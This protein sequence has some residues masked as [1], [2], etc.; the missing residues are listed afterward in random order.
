MRLL[1]I[2]IRNFRSYQEQVEIS[3][4]NLIAFVG[5][6]DIGKS[7]ILE[8]LDIF[9]NKGKGTIKM[10]KDDVNKIC[11]SE[12][13]K[14]TEIA[15]VFD[16]FPDSIVI[17]STNETSLEDEY[18]LNANGYLEIIK[19]YS[20]GGSEKVFIKANHPT[21]DNCSDLLLKTQ[22][23]LQGIINDEE[24]ECENR[25]RNAVMRASIWAHYSENINLEETEIDVT[26]G[27]TKSIW[28]KL[29]SYLF[30]F[31]I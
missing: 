2:K 3:A 21:N 20:N 22:R 17:D 19:R 6:N 12:E 16:Q 7:S 27:E 29:E 26:K 10:D 24:I 23:V 18:L 13:N 8:A 11:L 4:G 14:I 5:K 15:L 30:T 31:P 28:D 9:F 1:T 25:T